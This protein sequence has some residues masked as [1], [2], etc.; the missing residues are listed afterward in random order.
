M[1]SKDLQIHYNTWFFLQHFLRDNFQN[2]ME[3]GEAHKPPYFNMLV[4]MSKVLTAEDLTPFCPHKCCHIFKTNISTVGILKFIN[5][6]LTYIIKVR[7]ETSALLHC[8]NTASLT[9][10]L[11]Y[12]SSQLRIAREACQFWLQNYPVMQSPR[13]P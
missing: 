6:I 2:I 13:V 1:N 3:G 5:H 10:L 7:S 4:L 8:S 11:Y 9:L 12:S